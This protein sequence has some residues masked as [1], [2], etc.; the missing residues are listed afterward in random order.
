MHMISHYLWN[1]LVLW[2]FT[3]V[4]SCESLWSESWRIVWWPPA[5]LAYQ[6]SC[7]NSSAFTLTY[8]NLT[9]TLPQPTVDGRHCIEAGW[10]SSAM[11]QRNSHCIE[12]RSKQPTATE[13]HCSIY[14]GLHWAQHRALWCRHWSLQY[15]HLK[16]RPV[17]TSHF[18]IIH[19]RLPY[20]GPMC[21]KKDASKGSS[22]LSTS[23]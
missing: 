22:F 21:I 2:Y 18:F 12:C 16:G 7:E 9:T 4:F 5:C 3:S 13:V 6:F 14:R 20:W 10:S 15:K 17:R 19:Q 8:C 11:R 1:R 23:K